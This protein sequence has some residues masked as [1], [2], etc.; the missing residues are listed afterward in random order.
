MK[1]E[2]ELQS[3]V[4]APRFLPLEN[5]K[6]F[7]SIGFWLPIILVVL[8][9]LLPLVVPADR[10][11]ETREIIFT[12]LLYMALA[13]SLNILLGYSGYVS[14]GHIVFYGMGAYIG[15]YR[16][17]EYSVSIYVAMVAGGLFS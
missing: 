8:M 16:I 6:A 7:R 15:M 1:A 12:I 11:D 17:K 14:F 2:R 13:S 5:L 4:T 3:S 10:A 9:G